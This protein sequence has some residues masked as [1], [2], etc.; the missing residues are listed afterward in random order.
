[1][2][3]FK[4][5]AEKEYPL[6][7]RLLALVPAG[8]LFVLLIPLVLTQTM[9]GVD[10]KLGFPSLSFGLP[11]LLVAGLSIVIGL[12]YAF[13]SIGSQLFRARGTPLPMMATQKLLVSGPFKHCR[14]PMVLGTILLYLGIS[15]AVGSLSALLVILIFSALLL[16]YVKLVEEKELEA[17]FGDDYLEYKAH[18]PFLI[19]RLF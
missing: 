11:S 15:I 8:I 6:A 9:P 7:W 3:Q 2:D 10:Q 5:W 16:L 13:W 17:R 4:K 18:T 19:P 14:N 1:M 12:I